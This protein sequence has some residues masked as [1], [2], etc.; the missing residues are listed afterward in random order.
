MPTRRWYAV[1]LVVAIAA[2]ALGAMYSI[3]SMRGW[4][5]WGPFAVRTT[6]GP[7]QTAVRP[8]PAAPVKVAAPD[9]K[10][11]PIT[12]ASTATP[13]QRAPRPRRAVWVPSDRQ[14]ML[15][16]VYAAGKESRVD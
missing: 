6:T 13:T 14:V 1:L 16:R 12:V 5:I 4:R 8:T 11:A 10:P 2:I 7:R 9:P 15:D 3:P